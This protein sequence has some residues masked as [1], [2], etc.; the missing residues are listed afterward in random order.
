MPTLLLRLDAPMQSWGTDS[1][2]R[3]R[4][5]QLEPSKSGIIGLLCAAMGRGRDVCLDDL[6][7]LRLGVRVDRPGVRRADFHTAKDALS[8]SGK[9]LKDAKT[10]ERY[11]LE[12]ACFLVGLEGKSHEFLEKLDS[13][14]QSPVWPLYLGR[15]AFPPASPVS[16]SRDKHRKGVVDKSLEDALKSEPSLVG[17]PHIGKDGKVRM[18]LESLDTTGSLRNDQPAPGSTFSDRIF[19]GR[20]AEERMITIK[21]MEGENGD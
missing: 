18:V 1:I 13:A 8:A 21:V 4:T 17:Q 11:Y 16:L 5:T 9:V 10:S 7:S 15:R 19:I 6:A 20:Y 2:S 12:Q 14:L 3:I